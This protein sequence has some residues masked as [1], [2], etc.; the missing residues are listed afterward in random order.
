ML[1]KNLNKN[2]CELFSQLP[3]IKS[4]AENGEELKP[5]IN[6]A[7]EEEGGGKENGT[8]GGFKAIG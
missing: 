2:L 4:L 8:L 1:F 5:I 3:Q 6:N 7:V